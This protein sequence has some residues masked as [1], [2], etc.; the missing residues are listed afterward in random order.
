[1]SNGQET[2][3]QEDLSD[4]LGLKPQHLI[5]T[6]ALMQAWKK[7]IVTRLEDVDHLIQLILMEEITELLMEVTYLAKQPFK[8]HHI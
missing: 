7:Y 3:M 1:M 4:L 5:H 6:Q 2:T 8:F